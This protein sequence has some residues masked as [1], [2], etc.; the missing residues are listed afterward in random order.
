LKLELF[1]AKF[2]HEMVKAFKDHE[3]QHPT[4]SVTNDATDWRKLSLSALE[5]H[6]QEEIEEY[7]VSDS[8]DDL[9]DI[10]NMCFLVHTIRSLQ[11]QH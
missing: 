10:A 4:D 5:N 6:L 8:L 3:V 2:E 9:V 11:A 1:L 7:Q